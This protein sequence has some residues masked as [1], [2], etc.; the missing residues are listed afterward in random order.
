MIGKLIEPFSAT[1]LVKCRRKNMIENDHN[2]ID[3]HN[4]SFSTDELEAYEEPTIV[5]EGALIDVDFPD[6]NK[7]QSPIPSV[8]DN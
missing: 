1:K 4:D 2:Q 7:L 3:Q 6:D 8:K 5:A